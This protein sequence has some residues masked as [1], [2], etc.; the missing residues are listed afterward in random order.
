MKLQELPLSIDISCTYLCRYEEYLEKHENESV[1][2]SMSL[3]TAWNNRSQVWAIPFS[4]DSWKTNDDK[5]MLTLIGLAGF[6]QC[7]SAWGSLQL[8]RSLSNNLY[9]AKK[10]LPLHLLLNTAQC[11]SGDSMKQIKVEIKT[12]NRRTCAWIV[13][14][15]VL[16]C[17]AWIALFPVSYFIPGKNNKKG[18]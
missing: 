7:L 4:S 12:C 1:I 14:L 10:H 11:K 8:L 3:G 16:Y 13:L 17:I 2:L 18:S 5:L 15:Y 9:L 6:E